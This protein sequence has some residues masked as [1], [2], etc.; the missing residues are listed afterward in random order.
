MIRN[1]E[2]QKLASKQ[3]SSEDV[4][5]MK[6]FNAAAINGSSLVT[7]YSDIRAFVSRYIPLFLH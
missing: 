6:S 3:L 1:E 2:L 5:R 7:T 4:G